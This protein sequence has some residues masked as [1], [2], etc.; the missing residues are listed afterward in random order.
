MKI[1]CLLTLSLGL[2]LLFSSP[3]TAYQLEEQTI[4][5]ID[6]T[7]VNDTSSSP[8]NPKVVLSKLHSKSGAFF[9]QSALDADLKMLAH[10]YDHVEPEVDTIDD[11]VFITLKIWLKPKIRS[12]RWQG[13]QKIKRSKLQGELEINAGTVFDRLEFNR[14][15]QKV[16]AYYVKQ[17]FFEAEVDYDIHTDECGNKVDIVICVNEG[18]SGHIQCIQICGVTK[19][20]ECEIL[21]EMC[22]KTYNMFLSWYTQEGTY[23]EEM[24]QYDQFKILNY[25]QNL[26]YADA[27]VDIDVVESKKCNRIEI[28]IR[29]NKGQRYCISKIDVKGNCLFSDQ[30]IEGCLCVQEGGAYNPE[31]IHKSVMRITDLYGKYGYIDTIVDFEPNLIDDTTCYTLTINIEEG[32]QYRVGLIK[33]FGN[34]VTQTRVIL[35]ESLLFPGEVFNI[36][37]LKKT[38]EKLCNIGYF[39]CVNVYPAQSSDLCDAECGC[40]RDVHIEVEECGTGNFSA[41]FGFSNQESIFGGIT[42]SERNFDHCGLFSWW[43]KGLCVL[44]GGGEYLHLNIN[45]GQRNRTYSLSW[46]EPFY[47]D[48]PWTIGFDIE[49]SDS[50]IIDKDYEIE[51]NSLSLHASYPLNAFL[52]FGWHHR[53]R[54]SENRVSEGH[55]AKLS[56]KEEEEV[57]NDGLVSATGVGLFYDS[58]DSPVCPTCGFRSKLD[59]EIGAMHGNRFFFGFSYINTYYYPLHES[60][61]VKFRADYRY[62]VPFADMTY[63]LMP[64]DERI[65]LGGDNIIRGYRPYKVGPRFPGTDDPRGG[66]SMMLYSLEYNR[67][68]TEKIDAFTFF[69][70]GY[71]TS[72]EFSAERMNLSAGV[73]LRLKILGDGPPVTLGMGFPL[74]YKSRSDVKKFFWSLGGR[75]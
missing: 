7:F 65:F 27:E 63:T 19:Q 44:R 74:N 53:F 43:D 11:K 1:K 14:A 58:T 37:K 72:A 39:K 40:Y 30:D 62:L 47:N 61:V 66:L 59:L 25:L 10:E 71:L 31:A 21:K 2:F 16:K 23:N 3:L 26:G 41:F 9:S 73:G 68:V 45:I 35:H 54:Y 55:K 15:F 50:T 51:A 38:E 75:F 49:H 32:D 6:V 12:I 52:R 60:G 18:R 8:Q 56:P 33:V 67:K 34:C 57:N 36:Q 4:G 69:D 20:E 17:G 22:T 42:I 46:T 64:L 13:N 24:I 70:A 5:R 29:I 28:F 48:T